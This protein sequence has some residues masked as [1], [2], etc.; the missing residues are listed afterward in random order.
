MTLNQQVGYAG[1]HAGIW[2]G[3]PES[4]VDLNPAGATFSLAN[5]TIDTMQ[6]GYAIIDSF[7]RAILWF[8]AADNYIDLQLELGSQ[9]RDSEASSVWTDGNTILV[10]GRASDWPGNVHQMLWSIAVPE[11]AAGSFLALTLGVLVVRKR[12]NRSWAR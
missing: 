8:G 3:T 7:H 10:A 5:A 6:A 4:F 11:P 12:C 1:S 9:Y 2:F